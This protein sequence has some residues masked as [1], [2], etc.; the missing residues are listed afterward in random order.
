MFHQ[1]PGGAELLAAPRIPPRVRLARVPVVRAMM[2]LFRI[3]YDVPVMM[4]SCPQVM[5]AAFA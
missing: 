4:G 5:Q 2:V 1:G 3:G